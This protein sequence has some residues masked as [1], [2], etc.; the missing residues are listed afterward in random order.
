MGKENSQNASKLI[1]LFTKVCAI[2]F[3]ALAE[4]HAVVFLN[5]QKKALH[6]SRVKSNLLPCLCGIFSCITYWVSF[7]HTYLYV[8]VE[9]K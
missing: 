7:P 1:L 2:E 3:S 4:E 8:K 5:P 9:L 6:Y